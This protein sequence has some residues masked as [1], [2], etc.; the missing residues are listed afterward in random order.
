MFSSVFAL[1]GVRALVSRFSVIEGL[2]RHVLAGSLFSGTG[3]QASGRVDVPGK[4]KQQQAAAAKDS[5]CFFIK[6]LGGAVLCRQDGTTGHCRTGQAA[7]CTQ[8]WG[9]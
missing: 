7:R 5:I 4:D 8:V 9:L 6:S 1:E 3:A 2:N